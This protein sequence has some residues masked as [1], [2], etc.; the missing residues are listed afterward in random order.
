LAFFLRKNSANIITAK[1]TPAVTT[2]KYSL[3]PLAFGLE[4][5]FVVDGVKVGIPVET[6]FELEVGFGVVVGLGDV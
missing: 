1:I 3:T 5:I 2:R 4:G 6:G